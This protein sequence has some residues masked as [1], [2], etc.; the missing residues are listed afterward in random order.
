MSNMSYC[1][2]QNTLSDMRD[3][4]ANLNGGLSQDEAEAALALLNVCKNYVEAVDGSEVSDLLESD[5]EEDEEEDFDDEN[6]YGLDS[7]RQSIEEDRK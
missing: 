4:L 1:R 7:V 5:E 2:F 6:I 3:C